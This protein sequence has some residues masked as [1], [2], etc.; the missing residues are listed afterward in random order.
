MH[1]DV[2]QFLRNEKR[3][4]DELAALR[5]IALECKLSE[6]FKW[7]AP[8]YTYESKNIVILGSFK[9]SCVISFFKGALLKDPKGV[10][11]KPGENSRSA[12]VVRFT[13]IA[14]V[15]KLRT[16]LKTYI[17][18]AIENEKAGLKIDPQSAPELPVPKELEQQLSKSPKLAQA[19]AALTPG[20]QRAYLMH[21]SSAKQ[22]TTRL[23]RIEKVRPRILDGKGLNDCTCGLSRKMP[24]CDG[25]H[26]SL[27]Q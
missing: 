10:L 14:Q 15:K 26:K 27:K 13:S 9:E 19:F 25:S 6:T 23:A 12:M 16:T 17:R 11:E 24:G 8:C 21:I 7:R 4:P 18:E 20:R 1:P 3:W 5:E 22:S 2:H